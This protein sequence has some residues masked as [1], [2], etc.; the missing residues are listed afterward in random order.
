V[1]WTLTFGVPV[2]FAAF[3]LLRWRQRQAQRDQLKI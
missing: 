2:L 3:G 1:Q